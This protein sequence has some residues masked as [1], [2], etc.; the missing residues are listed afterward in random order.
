[1]EEALV[2]VV[3]PVYGVEA[4]LER[5]ITSIVRQTYRNL[6]ILLIDDGSPD[7]CPA[8]CDDWASRDSRIRVIHKQNAGLG[9][10]RNTGIDNAT[11]QYICFFDSDDYVALDTVEKAYHAAKEHAAQIVLFGFCSV[12][13][14]GSVTARHIPKT[15]QTVF[16]GREVL[17]RLLP[18]MVDGAHKQAR[19]TGLNL[20]ACM[21]LFSME[22]IRSVRW[23]FVS[24]REIISEDSYS[25]IDLYRSV[26]SVAI[27]PEPL[28]CYCENESSL[29]R[30]Y[31]KDRH[32]KNVIFYEATLNL[33]ETQDYG[34]EVRRSVSAIFW[35]FTIAAMKQT[36]AANISGREKLTQIRRIVDDGVVQQALADIAGRQYGLARAV[37]F[38]AMRHRCYGLC[39]L[40]PA[41]QNWKNRR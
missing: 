1:M 18:D 17:Q 41:A 30:S 7:H 36:M 33:L 2:T 8:I 31:R 16:R 23:R 28:Y 32:N 5:C 13:Q 40:L 35:G 21:C 10:A 37:L 24:E 27:L 34:D 4:Y 29:S 14:Q 11:G 3:I 15:E 26:K 38:W 39:C 12:D 6:E 20:S 9:M 19:N 25:L 22:L